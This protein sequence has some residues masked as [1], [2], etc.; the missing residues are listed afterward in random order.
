MR[1]TFTINSRVKSMG[2]GERIERVVFAFP[3][4]RESTKVTAGH[5]NIATK[6]V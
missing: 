2:R 1:M 5:Q 4:K 3:R 6:T